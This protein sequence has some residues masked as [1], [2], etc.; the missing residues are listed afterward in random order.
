MRLVPFA[1][2]ATIQLRRCPT[3]RALFADWLPDELA[4]ELW[5]QPSRL[6]ERGDVLQQNGMRRTV[7]I[8]SAGRSFVLKHYVELTWRHGLKQLVSRSRARATWNISHL[9]ADSGVMTP[10]PV[11][12]VENRLGPLRLDSYLMYPFVPGET[13][14]QHLAA[15]QAPQ[16]VLAELLAQCEAL[17]QQFRSLE[18]SLADANAG[19][20]IVTND[21]QLWVIDL[22]KAQRHWS[23]Q[24]AEWRRRRTWN[25]LVSGMHRA[26]RTASP[27]P[28]DLR[29]RRA[30]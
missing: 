17:W 23:R 9:L 16:P 6:V 8:H 18:V 27:V 19:N 26:A 1:D 5:E 10:R 14:K 20:F 2:S 29:P 21:R 3:R 7:R 4:G 24:R 22:D 28:A 25:Q 13:V 11:A 15:Q 12:C 30:A